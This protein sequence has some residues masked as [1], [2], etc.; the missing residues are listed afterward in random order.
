MGAH[1][2]GPTGMIYGLPRAPP[3]LLFDGSTNPAHPKHI[4]SIDPHCSVANVVRG[5]WDFGVGG[6]GVGGGVK[7]KGGGGGFPAAEGP[8]DGPAVGSSHLGA[9]CV[10]S[11]AS[12]S[13]GV[14]IGVQKYDMFMGMGGKK[15][16]P[17]TS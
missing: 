2:G 4:G 3:A 15:G 13:T 14:C 17:Q 6:Y 12:L 10:T 9:I 11:W 16:A 1:L 7:E 8:T 5:V